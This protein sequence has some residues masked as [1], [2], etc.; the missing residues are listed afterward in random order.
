LSL[1][2]H[3]EVRRIFAG[4]AMTEVATTYTVGG[5]K[6]AMRASEL[7]IASSAELTGQ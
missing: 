6:K 1:N 7:L 2:D 3:P 4:F 5:G